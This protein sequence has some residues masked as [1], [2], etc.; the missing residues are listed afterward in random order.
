M[1]REITRH[2]H[3]GSVAAHARRSA[4]NS[5]GFFLDL[6]APGMRVLDAGCGSGAIT[7][8]LARIVAPGEVLGIDPSHEAVVRARTLALECSITNVRF[9]VGDVYRLDRRSAS[10]D[11]V[12]AHQVL[13]N[14][15]RPVEALTEMRRV[16]VPRGL[17]AVREADYGTMVH[18]PHEP[19]LERWLE[20]YRAAARLSGGEPDAG[21]YLAG[22]VEAAAFV[23]I[24]VTTSTWTYADPARRARCAEVWTAR[25]LGTRLGELAIEHR[26]TTREVLEDLAEGWPSWAFQPHA[27][28]A[29]LHG[30]VL[31][32]VP[33]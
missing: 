17:L 11:V 5:A 20:L 10:F 15:A 24:E 8:D 9:E 7:C 19:R 2:P 23:D 12:Y 1:K 32:R 27:F 25:L 4:A 30:E 6:L 14:L 26:L 3:E 13:R 29:F 33:A 18:A 28:C 16:L 22:W 21:R 31:A